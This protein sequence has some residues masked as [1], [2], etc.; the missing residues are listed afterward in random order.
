MLG[1]AGLLELYGPKFVCKTGWLQLLVS[2][3]YIYIIYIIFIYKFLPSILEPGQGACSETVGTFFL[4]NFSRI[5][6]FGDRL[7][8]QYN[9][10]ADTSIFL[11]STL[12]YVSQHSLVGEE[13]DTGPGP[14]PAFW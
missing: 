10:P 14:G 4:F 8:S 3:I 2:L 11:F 5:N 9:D 6:P 7:P 1:R 13:G 12:S